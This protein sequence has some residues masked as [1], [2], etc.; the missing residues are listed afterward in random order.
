MLV[1]AGVTSAEFPQEEV[2]LI[3]A[4]AHIYQV[5]MEEEGD[6]EQSENYLA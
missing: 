3:K 5:V 4:T 2:K 1:V 6:G